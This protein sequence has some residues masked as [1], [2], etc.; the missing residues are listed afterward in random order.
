[1][2]CGLAETTAG[3]LDAVV[4]WAFSHVAGTFS[5]RVDQQSAAYQI[6]SLVADPAADAAVAGDAARVGEESI[7]V[8]EG[9]L[10]HPIGAY[11]AGASGTGVG[12]GRLADRSIDVSERGLNLVKGHLAR[13]AELYDSIP[14]NDAMIGRLQNALDAGLSIEGAAAS[15]YLHEASEASMTRV[16][17]QAGSTFDAAYDV[18]HSAALAKYDVSPFSVYRPDVIHAFRA[19]FSPAFRRFWGIG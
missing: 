3:G 8:G 14:Y 5:A 11:N 2:S 10:A 18:A 16:L 13:F 15:F 17:E 9:A 19:D 4:D 1:M 7:G 6:G 12:L